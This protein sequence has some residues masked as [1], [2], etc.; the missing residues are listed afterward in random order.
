MR[1]GDLS[2]LMTG[3][4]RLAA[5]LG[6]HLAAKLRRSPRPSRF[7]RRC[8][9]CDRQ[10]RYHADALTHEQPACDTWSFLVMGRA[11]HSGAMAEHC[12]ELDA[13]NK[14]DPG[15]ADDGGAA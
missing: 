10:V 14:R 2:R 7:P 6:E 5:A 13:E 11:A 8:H 15:P 3:A 1:S 9:W 4:G 12:A